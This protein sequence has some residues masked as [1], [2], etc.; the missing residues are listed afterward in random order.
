MRHKVVKSIAMFQAPDEQTAHFYQ[1]F[2]EKMRIEQKS[3]DDEFCSLTIATEQLNMSQTS[4]VRKILLEGKLSGVKL[5]MKGFQKWF[6]HR[7]SIEYYN[8]HF[9]RHAKR[10]RYTLKIH[11]DDVTFVRDAL[12]TAGIR[13]ELAKAYNGNQKG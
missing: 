10:Q 6:V 5:Q 7:D 12:I 1:L 9:S 8:D 3:L 4:Y 13:F 11:P 2:S